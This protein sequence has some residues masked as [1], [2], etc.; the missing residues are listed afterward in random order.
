MKDQRM[1]IKYDFEGDEGDYGGTTMPIHLAARNGNIELVKNCLSREDNVNARDET[2]KT[3]IHHALDGLL[4]LAQVAR[5]CGFGIQNNY[6][7]QQQT[8]IIKLL[9]SVGADIHAKDGDGNTPLDVA[10]A[11]KNATRRR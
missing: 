10:K 5:E 7:V 6:A 8:A 1:D 11:I 3:P 2:G 4:E 9:V